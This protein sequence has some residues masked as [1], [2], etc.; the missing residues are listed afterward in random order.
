MFTFIYI[1]FLYI[2]IRFLYIY[3][4]ISTLQSLWFQLPFIRST[5]TYPLSL[6]CFVCPLFRV[7]FFIVFAI[8]LLLLSVKNVCTWIRNIFLL[9]T[10]A[11]FSYWVRLYRLGAC[12]SQAAIVVFRKAVSSKG[13]GGFCFA[14]FS[15]AASE[16]IVIV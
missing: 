14:A 9:L 11:F 3:V 5:S 6:I 10:R 7:V 16:I 1:R 8:T 12:E 2:Y 15:L 4:L 13:E